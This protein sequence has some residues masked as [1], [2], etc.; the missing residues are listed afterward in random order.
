MNHGI[1][2]YKMQG[3]GND[4][5]MID[6][7]DNLVADSDRV[8]FVKKVCPRATAVGAD[9]VIFLENDPELDF[10]W[11][12]FN[13]DGSE[14]EMC[15]NGARC[16]AVFANAIGAAGS[17]MTFRTIAGS[18]DA[19][20]VEGGARVRLTDSELPT[21]HTGLEFNGLTADA[22]FINTGVPHVI[23]PVEDLESV[24]I[25]K[26]GAAI[27]YHETFKP[28]GTNANFIAKADDG[29]ILIRT[30]ERGVEDETLA[31]GTGS[32]AAA[33]VANQ[34]Y[35]TPAP[36]TIR[37]RSGITLKISFAK[38]ESGVRDIYLEGPVVTVYTGVLC[39]I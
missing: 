5:I 32:V 29:S 26:S 16:M 10:K 27:R 13:A 22:Y 24:D 3:S 23:V 25:K 6:N 14:A 36:V 1:T 2:F 15:G 19:T 37:T 9:G 20:I 18:I 21:L 28:A 30:Y 12:F 31:C 8:A 17:S 4:F 39:N 33:I 38:T 34:L 7:R 35:S 11:H